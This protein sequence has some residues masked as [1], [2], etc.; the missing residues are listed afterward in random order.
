MMKRSE[1]GEEASSLSRSPSSHMQTSWYHYSLF[2]RDSSSSSS[3][4]SNGLCSSEDGSS[5]FASHPFDRNLKMKHYNSSVDLLLLLLMSITS[6]DFVR[7]SIV[8]TSEIRTKK[9]RLVTIVLESPLIFLLI[10]LHWF[11]IFIAME[12]VL[13]ILVTTSQK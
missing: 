1:F 8:S 9:T 4:F 11:L 3:Y 7:A 13:V 12:R 2:P 5:H 6:W 10:K